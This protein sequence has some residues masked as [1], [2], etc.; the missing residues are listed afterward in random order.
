MTMK[1]IAENVHT[2]MIKVTLYISWKTFDGRPMSR[3]YVTYYGQNGLY[4]FFVL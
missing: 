2:G 3:S 4:D 1:R